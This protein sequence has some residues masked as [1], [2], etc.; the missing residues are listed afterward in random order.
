MT[1]KNNLAMST[2]GYYDR[3]T[4][5]HRWHWNN[6]LL[7]LASPAGPINYIR[8]KIAG[9][10]RWEHSCFNMGHPII[11]KSPKLVRASLPHHGY[12]YR[13][14]YYWQWYFS[15]VVYSTNK[16]I[17][18]SNSISNSNMID[19]FRNRN[20]QYILL[21]RY[22]NAGKILLLTNSLL[23]SVF[24]GVGTLPIDD[25]TAGGEVQEQWPPPLFLPSPFSDLEWVSHDTSVQHC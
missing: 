20:E 2:G 25:D 14:V 5:M 6:V 9:K 4:F 13:R 16:C 12:P 22:T 17:V 11:K 24:A 7:E 23:L 19:A 18:H 15:V 3:P 8:S 10:W 1:L 21:V